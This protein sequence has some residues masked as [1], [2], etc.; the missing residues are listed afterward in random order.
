MEECYQILKAKKLPQHWDHPPD[1][2]LEEWPPLTP[3]QE[4]K[5]RL[6]VTAPALWGLITDGFKTHYYINT[7]NTDYPFVNSMITPVGLK[8]IAGFAIPLAIF[9]SLFT[10]TSELYKKSRK[11]FSDYHEKAKH[12]NHWFTLNVGRTLGVIQSMQD[13]L[14]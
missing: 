9:T 6:I 13:A 1:N 3:Q 7:F 4:R 10:E 12:N 5:T 11:R 8:I 2:L 14:R